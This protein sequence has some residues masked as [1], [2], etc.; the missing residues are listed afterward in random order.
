[1]NG[2]GNEAKQFIFITADEKMKRLS[3][4]RNFTINEIARQL[5]IARN[6]EMEIFKSRPDRGMKK[7]VAVLPLIIVRR[8]ETG[9]NGDEIKKNQ[10]DAAGHGDFASLER[11]PAEFLG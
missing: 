7:S 3:V 10:H 8:N 2:S 1:M 9:K 11:L 4:G 6:D 5:F